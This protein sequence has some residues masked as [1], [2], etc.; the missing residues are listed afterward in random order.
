MSKRVIYALAGLE[1]GITGALAM[2]VWLGIGS[3]WTRHS[4]WWIPNLVAAV[5]YGSGSLRDAAGVYTAVGAAMILGLYGL[6]GMLF[7]EVF[8]SRQGGFRLFC[9]SLIIA[10]TVYWGILRWFWN[11]AN[12]LAH[13]Y[14]PDGQIL[15]GHILFGCFLAGYPR[16]FR[17]LGR[18]VQYYAPP[19]IPTGQMSGPWR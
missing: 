6:V 14:A 12:P 7:G 9:F 19:E 16:R 8:G 10:L 15:F 1:T 17:Q 2:L 5:T 4:I 18:A 11:A 13:V 3:V